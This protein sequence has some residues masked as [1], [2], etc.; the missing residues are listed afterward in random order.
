MSRTYSML[1]GRTEIGITTSTKEIP[2]RKLP[3]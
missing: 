3:A 1:K 2:E